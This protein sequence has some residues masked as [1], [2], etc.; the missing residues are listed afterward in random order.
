[1]VTRRACATVTTAIT[2][3]ANHRASPCV[4]FLSH[5]AMID[6]LGEPGASAPG[7]ANR[8]CTS[9]W[10]RYV[11]ELSRGLTPPVGL[12]HV[13]SRKAMHYTRLL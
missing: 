3:L 6:S 13:Q 2:T 4:T 8:V 7:D 1:M 12:F 10:R 5:A 9:T 11:R